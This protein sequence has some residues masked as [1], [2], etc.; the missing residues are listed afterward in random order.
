MAHATSSSHLTRG[1]EVLIL[2]G[3]VY[4]PNLG[5]GVIHETLDFLLHR[6]HPSL[7]VSPLDISGRREYCRRDERDFTA[8]LS[9]LG[10][11]YGGAAY[12]GL[13]ILR[14]GV[15]YQT[16]LRRLWRARLSTADALVIGGGQLLMDNHWDFPLKL[17]LLSRLAQAIHVPYHLLMVG[18]GG[19]WS[20]PAQRWMQSVVDGAE[21]IS[22]RDELSRQRLMSRFGRRDVLLASDPALWARERYGDFPPAT[23]ATIGLG[24]LNLVDFNEHRPAGQ[25]IR[26]EEWEG[27]WRQI[28]EG[29][30]REGKEVE[31]F[32]NGNHLDEILAQAVFQQ[33]A[34]TAIRKAIRPHSP[35]ELAQRIGAYQVVLAARLHASVLAVSYNVPSI[36]LIWDEK[37]GQFYSALGS[38]ERA[39][40]L[41][42][43]PPRLFVEALLGLEQGWQAEVVN[44]AKERCEAAVQRISF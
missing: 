4:S 32:T 28:A 22:V 10:R 2:A 23:R 12:R 25:K 15:S 1:H 5:D 35:H 13:N 17:Y 3:E 29:L 36:G 44:L 34:S 43:K 26:A 19:R 27:F 7:V 31:F 8:V 14:I 11:K 24:V 42:D 6:H 20:P 40:S 30:A 38:A 18:V 41:S 33:R 9:A 39:F 21:T 16:R 37:V